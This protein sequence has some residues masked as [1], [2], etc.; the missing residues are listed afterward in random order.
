[1][2]SSSAVPTFNIN[3]NKSYIL[4]DRTIF[5]SMNNLDVQVECPVDFGSLERNGVDIK[6]YFSAQHMDDY[7]KML[8]RPSYLN[9][10]K[11]FWVR[12]E[13]YDR[14]DAED[15]EAKLVKDNPT[16]KGK[17]RTE[18]GLRPFRGTKIRSA[19]MGME[20]TIT[21]ETIA[22]ACRCSNSGLFQIDAVKS[23]WEGKIN[24][25]LFGGNPKAKTS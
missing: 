19:V 3:T 2:A 11:D 12:A 8:N 18:M 10:V 4:K 9:M 24:G 7:F 1:M 22:R 16:L 13:V 20:I 17:S 14:R 15:E 21:Q 6:G 23:Q 5:V 25:V